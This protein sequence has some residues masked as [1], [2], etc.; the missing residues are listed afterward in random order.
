MRTIKNLRQRFCYHD[1]LENIFSNRPT[2]TC[3][4]RIGRIDYPISFGHR[5][6]APGQ[7]TGLVTN[8]KV[9]LVLKS[10]ITR[11]LYNIER[12]KPRSPV[13]CNT[14][15]G[16]KNAYFPQTGFLKRSGFPR[17]IHHIQETLH[18]LDI[19]FVP[20]LMPQFTECI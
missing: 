9:C 10:T 20:L 17:G 3:R 15:E 14:H 7:E 8:P 1:Y 19:A 5:P 4:K 6:S 18:S 16:R 12:C 11:N 13:C 2:A